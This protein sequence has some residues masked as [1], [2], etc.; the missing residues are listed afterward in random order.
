MKNW[1]ASPLRVYLLIGTLA[2]AGIWAGRHLSVSLFPNVTKPVVGV[3][4]SYPAITAEEFANSYGNYLEYLLAGINTPTLKIDHLTAQYGQNSVQ[5]QIEFGW[6]NGAREANREV[7]AIVQAYAARMPSEMRDSVSTWSWNRATGFF[8]ATFYSEKRSLEDLYTLLDPILKNELAKVPDAE[9]R[10]L[11]NPSAKEVRVEI[12]PEAMAQFQIWPR[13]IEQSIRSGLE[14]FGAGALKLPRQTLPAESARPLQTLDDFQHLVVTNQQGKSVYLS[15]LAKIDHV[16][17]TEFN[18]IFKTGGTPSLILWATPK[19]DGNVKRMSEDIRERLQKS[20][21][22]WPDDVRYEVLVDPSEFIAGAVRHTFQEILIG[23]LLAVLILFLFIGSFRN[24]LTTAIEI[25]I[26]MC[27]AFILMKLTGMNLNLV[28]LGGLALASGMN[29]DASVVVLENI[30]RHLDRAR[31]A[32]LHPN[33]R[34]SVIVR[35]VK[36]VSFSVVASTLASIVVFLPLAYTSELAHAVLG[37]LARAVIFSHGFSAL[38]ALILVPTVR[39][40]LLRRETRHIE[41]RSPIEPWLLKL[42]ALYHRSLRAF[43]L[44]RNLQW[45][46]FAGLTALLVVLVFVVLP[47]LPRELIGEPDTDWLVLGVRPQNAVRIQQTEAIVDDL[48]DQVKAKFGSHVR[49]TFA[50][51]FGPEWG[52]LNVRLNDK[53]MMQKLR[54]QFQEAFPSNSKAQIDVSAWNPSELPIPHPRALKLVA[55]GGTRPERLAAMRAAKQAL[56]EK[57]LFSSLWA[58][59]D[60]ERRDRLA[61]TYSKERWAEIQRSRLNLTRADLFDLARLANESKRIGWFPWEGK[62]PDIVLSLPA[63]TVET[64]DDLEGLPIGV[65]QRIVPLRALI[66]FERKPAEPFPLRENQ[67]EQYVLHGN[68][69]AGQERTA[70]SQRREAR[71]VIDAVPRAPGVVLEMEDSEKELNTALDQLTVAIGVSV[72]LIFLTMVLQFGSL[73]SSCLVLVSIP[74]GMIGVILSLWVFNSSLSLNSALGVILLNGIAVANSILLVDFIR[75]GIAAGRPPLDAALEAGR[76][77]L[78][79]ILITSLTTILAMVPVA[80]GLGEG[81]RILQP[82]GIAVAGGL[83]VS[84]LL[85]LYLVP[86]LQVLWLGRPRRA[87]VSAGLGAIVFVLVPAGVGLCGITPVAEA[88]DARPFMSVVEAMVRRDPTVQSKREALEAVEWSALGKRATFLPT[89]SFSASRSTGTFSAWSGGL[90][91]ELNVFRFGADYFLWQQASDEVAAARSGLADVLLAQEQTALEALVLWIERSRERRIN[92]TVL[93][94]QRKSLEIS[95]ARFRRGMVPVQEVEKL[96]VDVTQAEIY[97]MDLDI[98]LAR[99]RA[100]LAQALGPAHEISGLSKEWM[101]ENIAPVAAALLAR[102]LEESSVP[103]FQASEL[104]LSAQADRLTRTQRLLLPS[105]SLTSAASATGS[106]PA[107]V[108]D[109]SVWSVGL[110]ATWPILDGL[111]RYTDYRSQVHT[112]GQYEQAMEQSRR[113]VRATWEKSRER[114][115]ISLASLEA[116]EK[117]LKLSRK[118]YEDGVRRFQSGRVS[119]NELFVEHRRWLDGELLYL[120]AMGEIHRSFGEYCHALGKSLNS[121]LSRVDKSILDEYR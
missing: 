99:A 62:N 51:V 119:A 12:R 42:E 13:D 54:T 80:L 67:Q 19:S 106:V 38:V 57:A 114:F 53:R 83:W 16:P 84:T 7:A 59:P 108:F 45:A 90:S 2:G 46:T 34:L 66:Q 21:A 118:L 109:G 11:F 88:A 3:T 27:L 107:T 121:C 8:A 72:F 32:G 40:H 85:T 52:S 30:L 22:L 24:T 28:S 105:V 102:A 96:E 73:A 89:L 6:G 112:V 37:D 116:R 50:R 41:V 76:S 20:A 82:L 61:I 1:I 75:R 5:Y 87:K 48:E 18:R 95:R 97:L 17:K 111:T 15:D 86:A 65:G 35:A 4:V 43:L 55:R 101:F 74:L 98:A 25:P 29:V 71:S 94:L 68:V 26:S 70:E 77:R 58:E 104:S 36:E 120:R 92:E 117:S 49:G 93:E 56:E 78:R 31:L 113:N 64:E 100:D 110:Q 60:L 9:E 10:V 81:G 63:K 23:S 14:A 33:E 69:P 91:A 79:P 47:K 44:R 39:Y 115:R 103:A